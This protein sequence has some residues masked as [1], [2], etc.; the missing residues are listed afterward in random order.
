[1]A[2]FI[3]VAHLDED[4]HQIRWPALLLRVIFIR[5]RDQNPGKDRQHRG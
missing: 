1:V 3:A 4:V 5:G 2:T